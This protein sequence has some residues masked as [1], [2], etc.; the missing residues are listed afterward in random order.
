MSLTLIA[1]TE[2]SEFRPGVTAEGITYFLPQTQLHIT[3][4]AE[5]SIYTPGEYANYAEHFL[6]LKGVST[7]P[8]EQW[9]I[10]TI[11]VTPYGIPDQSRA[12]SIALRSKTSAPL[13][14]LTPEGILLSVNTETS[15]PPSLSQ[16]SV[17][18][19][20]STAQNPAELK[21]QE[22]IS[23]TNLLKAAELTAAE[24]YE[25]RENR[26]QLNKGEADYMPKDGEQLRIMLENLN[27]KESGL[28]QLFQGTTEREMHTFTFDFAPT[29]FN[30]QALTL[31]RFSPEYGVLEPDD[32]CGEPYT[33]LLRDAHTL[34]AEDPFAKT[35]KREQQTGLRYCVCGSARVVI[36]G[37]TGQKLFQDQFPFSQLGRIET[38]GTELFNK[39][40]GT[41]ITLNPTCGNLLNLEADPTA[42]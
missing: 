18:R 11:Q 2:I 14:S 37:P 16:P 5:R 12:Y 32:L 10:K 23:A 35:S 7:T 15:Q 8:R 38:I 1:Q 29:L 41:H 9:E 6:R 33:I 42:K 28:L 13:V 4:E 40:M 25:I 26:D 31:F 36:A 24:I 22:I 21:S 19:M 27:A 17:V 30:G 3:I 20:P 39:K 34:P